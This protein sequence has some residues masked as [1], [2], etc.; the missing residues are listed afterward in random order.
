MG[1]FSR[2]IEAA[3]IESGRLINYTKMASTVGVAVNT[4]RNFFQVL[5]D[6]FLGMRIPAF[7]ETRRRGRGG[8]DPPHA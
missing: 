2:F 5:E 8:R 1:A 3:A 7:T 6:T 4:L